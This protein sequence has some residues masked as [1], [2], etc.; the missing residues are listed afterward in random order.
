MGEAA[1]VPIDEPL[2]AFWAQD[3]QIVMHKIPL[4]RYGKHELC[5][6]KCGMA[7]RK[8]AP[9]FRDVFAGF[10]GARAP[11]VLSGSDDLLALIESGEQ[12]L[13][14]F[15]GCAP[16][17][18]NT[19][20]VAPRQLVVY[21]LLTDCN[22]Y[23]CVQE[24]YLNAFADMFSTSRSGK[25]PSD[26]PMAA[27]VIL[28]GE[29][30]LR[31]FE[32][33]KYECG[34]PNDRMCAESNARI[35]FR[36]ADGRALY[37]EWHTLAYVSNQREATVEIQN[38]MARISS[39]RGMPFPP[40]C[41]VSPD[42]GNREYSA[43]YA[44]VCAEF[45]S[46]LECEPS[47][48]LQCEN[49]RLEPTG[50]FVRVVP[51]GTSI[52]NALCFHGIMVCKVGNSP[53]VRIHCAELSKSTRA[54]EFD[55]LF[56]EEMRQMGMH[57]CAVQAERVTWTGMWSPY[58]KK[59][60]T[61]DQSREAVAPALLQRGVAVRPVDEALISQF[62]IYPCLASVCYPAKKELC[63]G[64]K[65]FFDV[66]NKMA[67]S[68][69]RGTKLPER[70]YSQCSIGTPPLVGANPPSA[71]DAHSLL[72][73][74][75]I[76]AAAARFLSCPT[77]LQLGLI[78]LQCGARL[79]MNA[80]VRRAAAFVWQVLRD[81]DKT[82]A[83]VC[84]MAVGATG[85]DASG[86]CIRSGCAASWIEQLLDVHSLEMSNVCECV[87]K[88]WSKEEA[89]TRAL[90]FFIH[91]ETGRRPTSA[92]MNTTEI[93]Q[94]VKSSLG[95]VSVG[96]NTPRLHSS[97]SAAI[98]SFQSEFAGFC[99]TDGVRARGAVFILETHNQ[100]PDVAIRKHHSIEGFKDC[101][102]AHF[103]Q[104][105]KPTVLVVHVSDKRK[106]ATLR[107]SHSKRLCFDAD[108]GDQGLEK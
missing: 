41:L 17:N 50:V 16:E 1:L 87:R 95:P 74:T 31:F 34:S 2:G 91:S 82:P 48:T 7:S 24:K 79:G 5:S 105:T 68:V 90:A 30:S 103:T 13:L 80:S 42:E 102:L 54:I 100:L 58:C 20:C 56:V 22:H 28:A 36:W 26:A 97:L 27:S 15:A 62:D 61:W 10:V 3:Q 73:D 94:V 72:S 101:T 25:L 78:M 18:K 63:P 65:V 57:I 37:H 45:A 85:A 81:L 40:S 98:S 4:P 14:S 29:D 47:V 77:D 104:A 99:G 83:D 88:R 55:E 75:T 35:C 11:I 43:I 39:S 46:A 23:H 19:G 60:A 84:R 64:Y 106:R 21:L 93:Q 33:M 66:C 6:R 89:A 69:M 108:G 8:S 76:S 67:Q 49:M 38:S 44:N 71:K 86:G 70:L 32:H 9:W 96:A 12:E 51:R 53:K 107:M 59:T 92:Y 52:Q